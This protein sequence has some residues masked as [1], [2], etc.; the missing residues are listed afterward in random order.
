MKGSCISWSYKDTF[1]VL[2]G[3]VLNRW[4]ML[5]SGESNY[6]KI[7]K[8]GKVNALDLTKLNYIN[9]RYIC[10]ALLTNILSLW[11]WDPSHFI[12][13]WWLRA[14]LTP[15]NHLCHFSFGHSQ[16]VSFAFQLSLLLSWTHWNWINWSGETTIVINIKW[17]YVIIVLR[18]QVC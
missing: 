10:S 16:S 4:C 7:S 18:N 11:L 3:Q 8:F 17:P 2:L 6:D 13:E 14:L 5:L 12:S 9:L 1:F 15:L